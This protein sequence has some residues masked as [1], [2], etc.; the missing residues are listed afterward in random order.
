LA[1]TDGNYRLRLH[2]VAPADTTPGSRV[3]DIHLQNQLVQQD[4][5][6]YGHAGGPL[7]AV[8]ESFFVTAGAG[9]GLSIHLVNKTY[10]GVVLAGIELTALN[11]AG[12]VSPPVDL[13]LSTNSGAT[14]QSIA[15]RLPL[16]RYGRGSFTWTAGPETQ[17]NTA[18]F[19]VRSPV[20]G[21]VQDTSD[22]AFLI[23]NSGVDYYVNDDSTAGDVFTSQPGDNRNSGKAIR[24]GAIATAS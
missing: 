18:L 14:W 22:S 8:A 16:D 7:K 10:G 6:L 17:G 9:S 23:A 4:Y 5:D 12:M 24:F 21:R 15:T 19:R 3:M 1:R 11:P 13:E 20:D 2:F